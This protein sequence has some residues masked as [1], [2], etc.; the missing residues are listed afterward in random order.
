MMADF[1]SVRL[2]RRPLGRSRVG[3]ISDGLGMHAQARILLFE[4]I[5]GFYTPLRRRL[6]IGYISAAA[7]RRLLSAGQRIWSV[8]PDLLARDWILETR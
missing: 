6:S 4:L 8:T 3:A 7:P 5:E 1:A 2:D